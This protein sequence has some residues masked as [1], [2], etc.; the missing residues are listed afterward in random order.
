M[1]LRAAAAEPEVFEKIA[2]RHAKFQRRM[3]RS[4]K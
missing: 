4:F 1:A 3:L 2:G